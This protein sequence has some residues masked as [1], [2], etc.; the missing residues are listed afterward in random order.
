MNPT[1]QSQIAD[2]LNQ[3]GSA[4]HTYE[5]TELK[6]VYDQDWPQWYAGYVVD[7]GINDVLEKPVTDDQLGQV[8]AEVNGEY[9]ASGKTLAWADFAASKVAEQFG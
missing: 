3:A 6:G 2:L 7:N 8:L 1:I 4:H 9:E 5:Q